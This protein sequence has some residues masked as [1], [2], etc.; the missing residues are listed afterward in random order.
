MGNN[1]VNWWEFP[2]DDLPAA[3]RFYGAV[4]GWKFTPFGADY[5]MAAAADGTPVGGFVTG[6]LPSIRLY[7][8]V[9]DLEGTLASAV[10]AGG[11][12]LKERQFISEEFGWW[13]LLQDANGH[14]FGLSTS[15][16]PMS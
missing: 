16:A 12:V 4:F 15:N 14:E 2:V 3:Q 8:G 6:D 11:K 5:S 9:D 10:A 13:A 7:T 1:T